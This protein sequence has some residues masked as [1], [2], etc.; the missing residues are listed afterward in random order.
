MDVF[1][2]IFHDLYVFPP[3]HICVANKLFPDG[4]LII[5]ACFQEI[6]QMAD[7]GKEKTCFDFRSESSNIMVTV[8]E[9]KSLLEKLGQDF[10]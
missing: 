10:K 2:S 7:V 8:T 9:N 6:I 4:N 3:V 5:F 1:P